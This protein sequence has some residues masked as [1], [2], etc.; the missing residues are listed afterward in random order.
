M[1]V[2]NITYTYIHNIFFQVDLWLATEIYIYIYICVLYI[3]VLRILKNFPFQV[4]LWLAM[5][6]HE[7]EDEGKRKKILAAVEEEVCSAIE[8]EM[9]RLSGGGEDRGERETGY[10][11]LNDTDTAVK[12]DLSMSQVC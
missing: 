10:N 4:D 2:C 6:M 5:E 9:S 7:L 3:H 1:Y 11:S 12:Q 8:G